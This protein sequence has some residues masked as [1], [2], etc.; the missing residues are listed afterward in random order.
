ME[1]VGNLSGGIAHDFN[2]LLMVISGST[3][4]LRD[5]ALEADPDARRFL[6]D[7]EAATS[8]A[9]LMTRQLLSFGGGRVDERTAV[10]LV[11]V[12]RSMAAMLPRLIGSRIA[13]QVRTP[14]KPV[15]VLASRAGLEQILL[16]LSVNA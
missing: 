5:G 14:E 13:V 12:V 11:E 10:D 15:V 3:S 8:R 1:V 9:T 2:N 16:N 6:D 7:I 4:L